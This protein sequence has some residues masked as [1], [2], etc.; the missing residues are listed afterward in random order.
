V[1]YAVAANTGTTSRTGTLTIGGNTFTV[2]Q[3]GVSCVTTVL[4]TFVSAGATGT[5]GTITVFA[6]TGCSWQA[7]SNA[8]WITVTAGATGSGNGTFTYTVAANDGTV[9]R[10]G[11][12]TAGGPTFSVNQAGMP[13]AYTISPASLSLSAAGGSGTVNVTTTSG[14]S[15]TATSFASWVTV[16]S[17]TAGTGSGSVGF[18]AAPNTTTLGR[19]AFLNIAGKS[20][21]IT[22]PSASC[23]FSVTPLDVTVPA[24]GG[25][26]TIAVTTQF[27]CGW[28]SSTSASW[29]TV[30]GSATGSGTA[31]YTVPANTG[32]IAR[33]ATINIAGIPV[34]VTQGA[35]TGTTT[36]STATG[37][38]T[39]TNMRSVDTGKSPGTSKKPL[40]SA[41]PGGTQ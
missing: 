3:P 8:T 30:A 11:T 20:F 1:T 19:T 36:L 17:G 26:G 29:I 6:P 14:C 35:A 39:P 28:G 23:A 7:R 37:P 27:L 38:A 40:R 31:T 33:S 34:N 13:C 10:T 5:A 15:W 25:T 4:P 12:V 32:T 16:S 2:T 41:A 18:T 9:S 24:G 22:E 21:L